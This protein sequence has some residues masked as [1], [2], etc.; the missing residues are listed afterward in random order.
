MNYWLDLRLKIRDF[1]RK[2]RRLITIIIIMW[3]IVIAINYFL[4][5]RTT[6]EVPKTT[7][8]PHIPIIDYTD[9]VP[10][11]YKKPIEN[12]INN[13]VEYC[14]NKEYEK[15]YNLLSSGYKE[16]YCGDIEKFKK[17]VNKNFETKKSHYI[18]NYS[19][20]NNTYIYQVRI[21]EDILATGTTGD[22]SYMEDKFVIKEENGILKL[23]LNGYCGYEDINRTF[24][25]ENVKIKIVRKDIFYNMSVYTVEFTNKTSNFILFANNTEDNEITLQMPD[26]ER[27]EKNLVYSNLVV[28]PKD[29]Y[30]RELTFTEY[31]DDRQDP[32]SL[33]FNNIRVLPEFTGHIEKA[34]QEKAKAIKLYSVSISL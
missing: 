1:F 16:K 4:K 23:S 28:Y 34:E 22:Y 29:T 24:E 32:V 33:N 7:Y 5:N 8:T 11:G 30:T 25:D 2:N 19:N 26:D 10:E 14:S 18:Q 27:K 3:S 9:S 12:L 15:A 13:F 17:Y 20:L 21:S 31:F 6:I